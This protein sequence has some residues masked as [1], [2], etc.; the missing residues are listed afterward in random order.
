MKYFYF[1]L[2]TILY[3]ITKKLITFSMYLIEKLYVCATFPVSGYV[4]VWSRVLTPELPFL[5]LLVQSFYSALGVLYSFLLLNLKQ[6]CP[7]KQKV[8]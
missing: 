3:L 4:Q 2:K 6:F 7:E 1:V 8:Q 5:P